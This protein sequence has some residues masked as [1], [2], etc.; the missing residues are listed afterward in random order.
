MLAC[1]ELGSYDTGNSCLPAF[2]NASFFPFV[3]L[4][5]VSMAL[6]LVEGS[7]VCE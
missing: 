1:L 2:F 5:E 4:K 6:A 3:I 7:L